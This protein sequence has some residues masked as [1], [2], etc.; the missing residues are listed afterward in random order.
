M[1]INLNLNNQSDLPKARLRAILFLDACDYSAAVREDE[2]ETLAR[3]RRDLNCVS[4]L[5]NSFRGRVTGLTGDG[6]CA[7]FPS[8]RAAVE[9]ALGVQDV[10]THAPDRY[11]KGYRI[12]IH[13]GDTFEVDQ[14]IIGDAVN[15]AARIE[16][17]GSSGEVLVSSV[18]RNALRGRQDFLFNSIGRPNLKNIGAT[19]ELF[20]VAR[21]TIDV[22]YEKDGKAQPVPVPT[23]PT[24]FRS[25][26]MSFSIPRPNFVIGLL[27]PDVGG[28]SETATFVSNIVAEQ[29]SKSLTETE[30]LEVQDYRVPQVA[31]PKEPLSAGPDLFLQCRASTCGSMLQV[32]ATAMRSE[33]R[34]VIW[35]QNVV[36]DQGD[37]LGQNCSGLT[38]FIS[39]ATD[40][41]LTALLNGRHMRDPASH[42]AAKTA[43]AAVHH[44][45]TMT[46]PGL[47]QLEA[48]IL[49]AYELDPK[50][51]YL[52]WL[53]YVT[54]FKV[55]ERYGTWDATLE[56]QARDLARRAVEADPDNGTVLGLVAHVHS[57]VF[58][59]FSVAQ[60]LVDRA[61]EL[62]PY[63]AMSWDSAAML[64][65]YTDRPT[66]AVEAAQKAR[67]IGRH[68]P[69]RHLFDGAGC[70]AALVNG[71]FEKSIRFGE[72]VMEVQP[73]FKTVMRYLAAAYGHAGDRQ[74]GEFALQRLTNLEPDMSL[75][76]IQQDRFPVPTR[77]SAQ[78]MESG[79][80]RIGLPQHA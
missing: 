37:F 58:R 66:L 77:F 51:V 55:G 6:L 15:T 74:R 73:Q 43:V 26:Q 49:A 25:E 54:T 33:D 30:A 46:G 50:P 27:S 7:V 21:A 38:S 24:A 4:D 71:E 12:G 75:A 34:K 13:L 1:G 23:K 41:L 52:A 3:I 17:V 64:Y 28:S 36:A 19:L 18:V 35:S 70:V 14:Q 16:S 76:C 20:K 56:A 80:S 11:A 39:Y 9:T 62:S 57:Y 42:H 78:L 63:R 22:P 59:E 47:D 5:V 40:A 67:L 69:Y 61:L 53:A 8:A 29:L 60:D 79:L 65:C 10:L 44:L 48:D 72:S 45:L 31:L 2:L 68:S 32:S